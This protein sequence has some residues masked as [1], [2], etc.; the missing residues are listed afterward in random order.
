MTPYISLLRGIN[1]S[2]QK[3]I[4]M[5]ELAQ[6][7]EHWGCKQVKTYIQ[8]GNVL[9]QSDDP[10]EILK[11]RIESGIA[12]AY[13]FQ[14]PIMVRTLDAWHEVISQIP[15]DEE[16]KARTYVFFLSSQPET[17]PWD[18]IEK[19]KKPE[20]KVILKGQELYLYCPIGLGTTKLSHH[21]FEKKLK[22]LATARNWNTV[23]KLQ[24]LG[25]T[26]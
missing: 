2:G 20:E 19:V 25:Q 13:G 14:V 18:A 15:F 17:I 24:E 16:Q 11:E 1:V 6:H 5:A 9:F 3:L 8:S 4:K 7:Y 10:Q 22:V 21:F 23:L 12:T 26:L